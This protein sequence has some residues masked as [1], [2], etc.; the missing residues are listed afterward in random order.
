[1]GVTFT[2]WVTQIMVVSEIEFLCSVCAR[3]LSGTDYNGRAKW[4]TRVTFA[5]CSHLRKLGSIRLSALYQLSTRGFKVQEGCLQ[6]KCLGQS[7]G[8]LALWKT[9]LGDYSSV[10][11][12]WLYLPGMGK[13]FKLSGLQFPHP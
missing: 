2:L 7:N 8:S 1:M 3:D 10:F 4:W 12:S 5:C 9:G 6:I 11:Q 13:P